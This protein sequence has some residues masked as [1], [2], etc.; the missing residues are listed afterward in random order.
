MRPVN[1]IKQTLISSR[2]AHPQPILRFSETGVRKPTKWSPQQNSQQHFNQSPR[3]KRHYVRWR[4]REFFLCIHFSRNVTLQGS[5]R[6]QPSPIKS[7]CGVTAHSPLMLHKHTRSWAKPGT[8]R[9]CQTRPWTRPLCFLQVPLWASPSRQCRVRDTL[10]SSVTEC[11]GH[12]ASVYMET[13]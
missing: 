3:G 4:T 1:K 11:A 2:T 8:V 6:T 13:T 12:W 7:P 9:R 10:H 5:C